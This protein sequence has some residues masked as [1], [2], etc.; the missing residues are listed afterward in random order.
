MVVEGTDGVGRSTQIAMLQGVAGSGRVR[1][2]LVTGF[3]RSELAATG[4][5]RAMRGNT[6]DALTLN[7]F[8]RH[9]LLGPLGKEA[10][11]RHSVPAWWR[12]STGTSFSIIARARVRGVPAALA[13]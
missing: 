12:W 13:E 2:H 10:S 7:L 11:C 5:N 1:R 9:R 3:R 6:L 8:L 4:I